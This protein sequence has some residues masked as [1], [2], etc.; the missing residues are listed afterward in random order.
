MNRDDT[1]LYLVRHGKAEAGD[2][3]DTR[4]LTAQG[5]KTVQRVA[6]TLL[7]ANV[8]VE[9]VYHSGLVRARETAEILATAVGGT[10]QQ[11]PGLRPEDR[12]QPAA[13]W[14]AGCDARRLM[15]V[16]HLPFMDQLASYLLTGDDGAEFCHFRTGS[17]ACLS[18]T[19]GRWTLEWLLAPDLL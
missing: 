7:Q 16:G 5:R 14:I 11:T 17:V 6:K 10:L 4:Q 19:G 18:L 12:V 8:R 1:T 15:L 9:L 13:D 2:L 3:D